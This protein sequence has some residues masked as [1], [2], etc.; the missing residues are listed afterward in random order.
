MS[1]SIPN[2]VWCDTA[3]LRDGSAQ[4]LLDGGNSAG[5]LEEAVG[6]HLHHS[7]RTAREI[8]SADEHSSERAAISSCM[9]K[10][11]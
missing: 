7:A 9:G 4:H 2:D 5:G 1:I 11:S 3:A 8:S 10:I 6:A